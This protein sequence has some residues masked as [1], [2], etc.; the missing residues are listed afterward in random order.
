MA[1]I[2]EKEASVLKYVMSEDSESGTSYVGP[3][4]P[5]RRMRYVSKEEEEAAAFSK[6]LKKKERNLAPQVANSFPAETHRPRLCLLVLNLQGRG[7]H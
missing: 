1:G 6:V 5:K 3:T 2:I 7:L 4:T